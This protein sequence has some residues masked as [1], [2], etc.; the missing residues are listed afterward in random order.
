MVI[1]FPVIETLSQRESYTRKTKCSSTQ[2]RRIKHDNYVFTTNEFF[3]I[4]YEV[5]QT[6]YFCS[7]LN[8]FF[9][10]SKELPKIKKNWSQKSAVQQTMWPKPIQ[11]DTEGQRASMFRFTDD[12]LIHWSLIIKRLS[13]SYNRHFLILVKQ[14]NKI[15]RIELHPIIGYG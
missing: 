2:S 3:E 9:L 5:F 15:F 8:S 4:L 13:F 11:I 1:N 12:S 10:V 6:D 7:L 14:N